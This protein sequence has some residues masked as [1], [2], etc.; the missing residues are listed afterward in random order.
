MLR[1]ADA[2][3]CTPHPAV[4]ILTYYSTCAISLYGSV[5]GL[6]NNIRNG[7]VL[8]Y[9]LQFLR[10]ESIVTDLRAGKSWVLSLVKERDFLFPKHPDPLRGPPSPLLNGCRRLFT[11]RYSDGP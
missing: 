3:L 10:H 6:S 2:P 4:K 7:S 11:R 8:M 1:V 5:S 9:V